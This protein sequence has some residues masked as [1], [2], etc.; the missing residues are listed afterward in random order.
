M[1]FSDFEVCDFLAF[2]LDCTPEKQDLSRLLGGEAQPLELR[3]LTLQSFQK[4]LRFVEGLGDGKL[5]Y[6]SERQLCFIPLEQLNIYQL[7][8]WILEPLAS[9][10]ELSFAEAVHKETV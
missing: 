7:K 3:G 10:T 9:Q 8:H 4:L 2:Q 6:D 5:W 1:T